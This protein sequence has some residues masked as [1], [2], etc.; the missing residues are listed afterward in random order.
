MQVISG[1]LCFIGQYIFLC[2]SIIS[3]TMEEEINGF[4]FYLHIDGRESR[5]RARSHRVSVA[6]SVSSLASSLVMGH[7]DLQWSHTHQVAVA[8]SSLAMTL[9]IGPEPISYFDTSDATDADA[10][11]RCEQAFKVANSKRKQNVGIIKII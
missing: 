5:L 2:S 8:A 10:A 6:A 3:E 7:I 9:G 4:A 11:A 1:Y